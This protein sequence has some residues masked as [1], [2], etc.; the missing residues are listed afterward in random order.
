VS[1]RPGAYSEYALCLYG[2]D[3]SRASELQARYPD[4][5]FRG[6]KT[7]AAS[8]AGI[9]SPEFLASRNAA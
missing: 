8:R 7:D 5:K 1:V 3:D 9:Y 2:E 4:V 6:F